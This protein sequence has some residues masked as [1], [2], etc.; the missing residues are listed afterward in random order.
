MILGPCL[1]GPA[2]I[3][4]LGPNMNVRVQFFPGISI[5]LISIGRDTWGSWQAESSQD[6]RHTRRREL[7]RSSTKCSRDR[8]MLRSPRFARATC[9]LDCHR[10][11]PSELSWVELGWVELM[12]WSD[13][14]R[15]EFVEVMLKLPVLGVAHVYSH[16]RNAISSIAAGLLTHFLKPQRVSMDIHG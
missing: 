8:P 7:R 2:S 3:Q 15:S 14:K 9:W 12:R 13:A 10:R 6:D 16:F 11:A 4:I 1:M 5:V